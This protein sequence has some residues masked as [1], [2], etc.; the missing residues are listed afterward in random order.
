[1]SVECVDTNVS[2]GCSIT[3]PEERERLRVR[4]ATGTGHYG[5]LIRQTVDDGIHQTEPIR[6]PIIR[7][8]SLLGRPGCSAKAQVGADVLRAQELR[9]IISLVREVMDAS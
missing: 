3:T 9:A 4:F 1:M 8:V 6:D 2:V 7:S 5:V